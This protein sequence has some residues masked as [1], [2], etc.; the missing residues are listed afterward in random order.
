MLTS[1]WERAGTSM[2]VAVVTAALVSCTGGGDAASVRITRPA[3]GVEVSSS[4]VIVVLEASGIE[5]APVADGRQN[6]AHHHLFIDRDLTPL[7][8]VIPANV[9]GIVHL[10]GGQ[11][12]HR[13]TGLAPGPHRVIAVL[14][15]V[16]PLPLRPV[17]ADTVEFTILP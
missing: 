8:D 2:W 11:A 1:N 15:D 17:A 5:I 14:A 12:E 16:Q 9:D 6:T 4:E 13:L 10:G 3:D 7:G